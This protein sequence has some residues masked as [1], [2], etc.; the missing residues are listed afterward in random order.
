MFRAI[1]LL[2]EEGNALDIIN[3]KYV[4]NEIFELKIKQSSNNVRILYFFRRG[5]L[6][7]LTHGFIKKTQKIP[8]KELEIAINRR[9]DFIEREEK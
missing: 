6:I 2:E 5:Q 3:S 4:T 1:L 7:I 8:R 9:N